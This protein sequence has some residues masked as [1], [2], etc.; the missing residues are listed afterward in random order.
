[1]KRL[2][3][4]GDECQQAAKRAETLRRF[5]ERGWERPSDDEDGRRAICAD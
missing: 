1:M 4:H 2:L 5:I 3:Q